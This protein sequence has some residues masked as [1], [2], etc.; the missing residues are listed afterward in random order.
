MSCARPGLDPAVRGILVA[1][2]ASPTRSRRVASR[3]HSCRNRRTSCRVAT[4]GPAASASSLNAP[5]A[6]TG[7]SWAQS[8]TS[9]TFAPAWVAAR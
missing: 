7:D 3:S 2:V 5:P 1:T 8:P 9:S 6:C 4:P